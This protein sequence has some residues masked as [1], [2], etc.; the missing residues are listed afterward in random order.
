[1]KKHYILN[2]LFLSIFLP[3]FAQK[4]VGINTNLPVSDLHVNG[5][6]TLS[7][8]LSIGGSSDSKGNPGTPGQVLSS[9]GPNN[10]PEWVTLNIPKVVPGAL[11]LTK[12]LVQVDNIGVRINTTPNKTTYKEDEELI[13]TGNNK[14]YLFSELTSSVNIVDPNNKINFTI[15]T[16][17]HMKPTNSSSSKISFNIGVFIDDKLKAIRPYYVQGNTQAFTIPTMIST[18]EN[19]PVGEHTIKIAAIARVRENYSSDLTIGTPNTPESTNI[20]PFMAKT[21]LKI[22]VFEL[23][24]K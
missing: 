1:M 21:S 9:K 4:N 6:M 14:W 17:A 2:I 7:N 24:N 8:E 12:S 16:I 19:L 18:I 15:Q 5:S 3:V 22:E 20:S 13:V 23:L 10:T 11:S